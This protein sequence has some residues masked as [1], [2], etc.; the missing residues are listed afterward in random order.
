MSS[1]SSA[2]RKARTMTGV[3]YALMMEYRAEI[4]LWMLAGIL[5][6]ILMG[7]WIHMAQSGPVSGF[8]AVDFARYFFAVFIVRQLTVVWVIWEFEQQIVDGSLSNSLLQPIDPVFRHL[9]GH[10]GER[11]TRVPIL[12]LFIAL[13]FFLYPAS[14]WWPGTLNLLWFLLVVHLAFALRFVI[15]YTFALLSFWLERSMAIEQMWFLLYLFFS[16]LIAPLEFYPEPLQAFIQWTP[17]PYLI[18]LPVKV[19][20]GDLSG[21]IQGCLIMTAWFIGFYILNRFLWKQGLKRYSGM[22]A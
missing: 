22:G 13:F 17:F 11:L 19:L 3:S 21:V 10:M 18:Y 9:Y 6:L 5:P 20:L 7:L 15:Q 12:I 8:S 1:L 4:L 2:T 16:G 14:I